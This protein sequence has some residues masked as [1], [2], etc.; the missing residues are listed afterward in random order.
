MITMLS[1]F[2]III[3]IIIKNSLGATPSLGVADVNTFEEYSIEHLGDD[4]LDT[5]WVPPSFEKAYATRH[6]KMY[7]HGK[8]GLFDVKLTKATDVSPGIVLYFEFIKS[9]GYMLLCMT[10]LSIPSIVFSYY[11]NRIGK[12]EQDGF[13]FYQFSIG[14]IGYNPEVM[15]SL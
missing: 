8:A 3:F 12:F 7:K 1:N 15:K 4:F 2:F 13:G 14:N 9:V 6:N 5:P 10:L 11:G